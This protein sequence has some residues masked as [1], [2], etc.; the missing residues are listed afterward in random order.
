M[1]D[2]EKIVETCRRKS[3]NRDIDN[4]AWSHA[5]I[6]FKNFFLAAKE[7]G[8]NVDIVTGNL[9]PE[10]YGNLSSYA[11][12]CLEAGLKVRLIVLE[13]NTQLTNN[14]FAKLIAAHKN[15]SIY[16]PNQDNLSVPHFILVG[17]NKYRFET[18]HAQTKAVANFN[19][20]NMGG[21]LR[22]LINTL[23]PDLIPLN[24]NQ[25]AV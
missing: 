8:E 18:D 25:A 6:L 2:F 16:M 3:L 12:E 24:L 4:S 17:N 9:N 10:F 14:P 15:G 11:Q 21:F 20:P 13:K 1:S 19:N 23:Q 7:V 22:V 5:L